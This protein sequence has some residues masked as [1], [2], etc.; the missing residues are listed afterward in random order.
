MADLTQVIAI[1]I[2]FEKLS[3]GGGICRTG[4]VTTRK[5]KD[6]A[7]GINC[8]AANFTKIRLSGSLSGSG[9][10]SKAMTGGCCCANAGVHSSA[11]NPTSQINKSPSLDYLLLVDDHGRR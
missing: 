10:E 7:G 11:I 5:N 6:V 1:G 9:T 3:C 4:G 8:Y 2:K